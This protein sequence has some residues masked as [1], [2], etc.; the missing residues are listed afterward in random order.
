MIDPFIVV[1]G[2]GMIIALGVVMIAAGLMRHPVRLDEAI[3]NLDGNQTGSNELSIDLVHDADSWLERC[4][5]SLYSRFRLPIGPQTARLLH[6]HDRSLGDFVAEKMILGLA[7]LALP[8]L[9]W[10]LS[11]AWGSPI[12]SPIVAVSLGCGLLGW[13]WPDISLRRGAK[14]RRFDTDE[15]LLTLF[16]LVLLERMANRSATQALQWAAS[17]SDAPVF[18]QV[19]G[20]LIQASLEQRPPWPGLR[21]LSHD[22]SV[23]ALADLADIMQLDEQGASLTEPLAAR[24]EELR[25][26]HLTSERTSAHE[27]NERMTLWMTLPVMIFGIALIIPPILKLSG[28]A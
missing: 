15:A 21:R 16:D 23:P 28:L 11:L 27:V 25:D 6:L 5:A 17:V 3:A 12:G 13:F 4:G 1:A 7:G 18:R 24:V 2:T 20:T 8:G 9:A 26:A 14:E 10:A 19:R 22:L